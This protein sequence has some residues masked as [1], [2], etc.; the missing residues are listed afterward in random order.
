M[1]P[2]RRSRGG[3]KTFHKIAT[4]VGNLSRYHHTKLPTKPSMNLDNLKRIVTCP[5][6][7]LS[8]TVSTKYV[9]AHVNMRSIRNKYLQLQHYV[10]NEHIDLCCV[11][12]TWLK[13]DSD[14]DLLEKIPPPGYQIKSFP[15][16]S[17]S[18]GGGIALIYKESIPVKA[19]PPLSFPS[20]ECAEFDISLGPQTCQLY[21]IYRPPDGSV[22]DFI[23]DFGDL[24]ETSISNQGDLICTG[25]LNVHMDLCE[26]DT[27]AINLSDCLESFRLINLVNFPTH[28][29]LHTLDLLLVDEESLLLSDVRRG[30]MFAD[31]N[32]VLTDI[33]ITRTV[34]AAQR[35]LFRKLKKI[36][37]S[38][39]DADLKQLHTI[40]SQDNIDDAVLTYTNKL[41]EILDNHAPMKE[42]FVKKCHNQPWFTDQIKDEIRLRRTM[43]RRWQKTPSADNFTAFYI[44][45]RCV[46]NLICREQRRFYM[47]TLHEHRTDTK[48]VFQIVNN[49][50]QRKEDLPLPPSS[51]NKQL[52]DQFNNFFFEKVSRIR[53]DLHPTHPS[54]IDH[55]YIEKDFSTAHRF[56]TFA[57]LDPSQVTKIVAKSKT[58][59]CE[60]DPVPTWLLKEHSAT[61][62]PVLTSI[63]NASL[64]A[65]RFP[66]SLKSALVRPL[67]K[68][69]GLECIFKNYRPVSNL[70]YIGKL[71]EKA[72]F[73]QIVKQ[74]EMSGNVEVL[75]SAY[76][77]GHCTETALLRVKSD[78]LK[79]IENQ[80]VTCLILLDLSAAFD[81]VD[82]RLLLTRL[83]FRFGFCDKV[84][85]WIE[86]YLC[87]R[88]QRVVVGNPPSGAESDDVQ[89]TFG[90][91]QGSILGPVLFTLYIA[92]LGDI[93]RSH[94]VCFHSYADDQQNYLSFRPSVEGAQEECIETLQ[95]CIHDIRKWMRTN[96][97]KLNES[98]TEFLVTGTRQQLSKIED[99]CVN[100]GSDTICAAPVV[101]NLGYYMDPELKNSAHINKITSSCFVTIKQ[102]AKIRKLI[103]QD[104][105][106]LI[107]QSLILS[108]MDYC[109]SLL[110]GTAKYQLKKLQRIQNMAGRVI[111]QLERFDH[112]TPALIDLHW[113]KI[114]ERITYK[115]ATLVYKCKHGTA[116]TY[117]QEI[118]PERQHDRILRSVTSGK[119]P[120]SSSKNAQVRKG[121]FTTIGPQTW[122]SLP[123]AVTGADTLDLFKKHLKTHLFSLS[124][125][126]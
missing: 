85:S 23:E 42:K 114:E 17:D 108:R 124:Y 72:V 32:T 37:K 22:L 101:R 19:A 61:L 45:R 93:C 119:L 25:D 88:R 60:L 40:I 56:E 44:Q 126:L 2:Y 80:E 111:F 54:D 1:H 51:D 109:N 48:K 26:S 33:N 21:V 89:L 46:S 41:A 103:D 112:I 39:F 76:R 15:R 36:N 30:H 123:A 28:K 34:P 49:L 55:N 63:I 91:P 99:I 14:Q 57:P 29:D 67:L 38:T 3:R 73:D 11:T 52:A 96:L 78:M 77:T 104:T 53:T 47:N 75:Q 10:V 71:I 84:L 97:L 116:P 100:I 70:A 107:M 95:N 94:N 65:G 4:I 74:A 69:R 105:A 118:L 7:G 90:V 9:L 20:M 83:K 12:E 27:N 8:K 35:C 66:D 6:V 43:E 68:K 110:A 50:L 125:K 31:H 82:H 16:N 106:Q 117:L 122:N 59:S 121:D 81:T 64:E 5:G 18:R 92:P 58:K 24:M 98:K 115:I 62:T 120:P 86:T 113:L 13:K 87:N 79:A 102:C